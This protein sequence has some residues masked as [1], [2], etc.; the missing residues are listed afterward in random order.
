MVIDSAGARHPFP[1]FWEQIFG[2]GP[3]HPVVA[4]QLPARFARVEEATG[5]RYV[6]FHAIFHDEVGFY[7]RTGVPD[8]LYNF[9]YVDQIYDGLLEDGVRPFVELSFMPEKL[10][11]DAVVFPAFWYKPIISPPKDYAQLGRDDRAFA[12]HL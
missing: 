3:R 11:A 8:P 2:S 7:V 4:R 9:S 10:A 6:R 12:Q 1:H 5:L